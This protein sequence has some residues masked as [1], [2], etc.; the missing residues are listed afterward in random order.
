MGAL[1]K[2]PDYGSDGGYGNGDEGYCQSHFAVS[3]FDA[4][5]SI[6]DGFLVAHFLLGHG[7]N[8]IFGFFFGETVTGN[9]VYV[10]FEHIGAVLP[11]KLG[12][13]CE[14]P[15]G[16]ETFPRNPLQVSE[17]YNYLCSGNYKSSRL[18]IDNYT[19]RKLRIMANKRISGDAEI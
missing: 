3:A 8:H 17:I 6:P 4:M 18:Y 11:A 1:S 19:E 5:D 2:C 9:C 12:I 16:N 7:N 14:I 13:F 10:S 15:H